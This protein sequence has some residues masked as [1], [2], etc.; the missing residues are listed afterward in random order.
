VY[1]SHFGS[2]SPAQEYPQA[3]YTETFLPASLA[4]ELANS[5]TADLLVSPPPSD[6]TTVPLLEPHSY[7]PHWS[8]LLAHE[9]DRLA[10]DKAG[11]VLWETGI[12]VYDWFATEFVISVPGI[13]ENYPFLEVGDLVHM[14]EVLLPHRTP[15]ARA[16]EGRIIALRKREGLVS[17]SN[18]A[19]T[20]EG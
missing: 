1:Y 13:R 19:F 10:D 15:S 2:A 11:V 18:E 5:H 20:I 17:E 14:R 16:F 4:R 12:K 3:S 6:S 9:L 8:H 7:Y